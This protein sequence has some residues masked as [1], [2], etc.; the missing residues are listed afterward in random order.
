MYYT[1]KARKRPFVPID[2]QATEPDSDD[3][4]VR[5]V[6]DRNLTL[7]NMLRFNGKNGQHVTRWEF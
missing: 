3:Q 6:R 2:K 5:T 7:M 4:E 1:Q